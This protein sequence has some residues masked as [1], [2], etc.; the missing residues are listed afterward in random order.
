MPEYRIFPEEEMSVYCSNMDMDLSEKFT[1]YT[2]EEGRYL[3]AVYTDTDGRV[4]F[5]VEDQYHTDLENPDIHKVCKSYDDASE[6]LKKHTGVK[7]VDYY[8]SVGDN[9]DGYPEELELVSDYLT[10]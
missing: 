10:T 9:P 8:V 2:D 4:V 6:M 5:T 1:G 3:V 7:T